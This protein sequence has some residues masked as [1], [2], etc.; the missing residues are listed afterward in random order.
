[1]KSNAQE[2]T[3]RKLTGGIFAIILLTICLCITTYALVMVS[4]SIPNN[5][6]RTGNIEIN[7][8]DGLPVIE[9]H[10]FIFEPGMTVTKS[11]FIENLS[12][13][14]VYYKIYFDDVGGGLA[15]ILLITISDGEKPLFHGTAAELSK[16]NVNAADDVLMM[17]EKRD[18]TISFHYPEEAGN[19]T[20]SCALS[21]NLCAEAV[22]TKN[23]PDRR[24]D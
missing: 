22:Q 16:K 8:N 6:F 1:M 7:L 5:Y 14:D 24:F 13:W 12:T 2:K 19:A 3:A 18:L 9:E 15:D 23:N 10:E 21:F 11:F 17:K 4:V 20:Q